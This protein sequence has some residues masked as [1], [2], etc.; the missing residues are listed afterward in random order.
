M[1]TNTNTFEFIFRDVSEQD[2]RSEQDNN[3]G[4]RTKKR[5]NTTDNK[6]D[7]S[8]S[9]NPSKKAKEGTSDRITLKIQ[10]DLAQR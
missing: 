9:K 4:N 8:G 7:K 1:K 3:P 6:A 2:D 10:M 5:K